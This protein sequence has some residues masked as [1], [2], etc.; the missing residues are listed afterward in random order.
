MSINYFINKIQF[1]D[2]TI[3]TGRVSIKDSY[4]RDM[5]VARMLEMGTS[6]GKEDIIGVISLLEKTVMNVCL[7]GNKVTLDGFMQF[8]PSISGTFDGETD[9]FD[10][11]R[12]E[13]YI[14]AQ[15]SSAYN[16][17]FTN[18]ASIEKI[19]ATEKKPYLFE[20]MD[21]ESGESNNYVTKSNIVMIRGEKLKFDAKAADEYLRF[22]NAVDSNDFA[23]INKCQKIKDKEIV[24]LMPSVS[25][26]KGYFEVCSKMG[27]NETRTGK[28]QTVEV[29]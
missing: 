3:Y 9:S 5:V 17:A 25:F 18:E 6:L 20:V 4:D 1:K 16:N 23:T 24:F 15:I 22:V 2:G 10:K 28:S 12:N 26:A 21:N 27:T 19:M 14:T 11:T 29:K 13:V 8:T 7:E